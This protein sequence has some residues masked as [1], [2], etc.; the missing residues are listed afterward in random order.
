MRIKFDRKKIKA[1]EIIKKKLYKIKQI[2][3]KKIKTKSADEKLKEDDTEKKIFFYKL[4][5]IK[6]IIIK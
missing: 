5:Q 3:I 1:G 4:F 6:Q 2:A